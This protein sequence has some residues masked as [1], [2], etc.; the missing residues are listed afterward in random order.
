MDAARAQVRACS[1]RGGRSCVVWCGWGGDDVPPSS[2]YIH[3]YLLTYIHHPHVHNYHPHVYNH[4]NS[5]LFLKRIQ[6]VSVRKVLLENAGHYPLEQPGI[7]QLHAAMAEF[8]GEVAAKAK[9]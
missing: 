7:D 5:E 3:T 2:S 8:V 6:K 4:P 1:D 9:K